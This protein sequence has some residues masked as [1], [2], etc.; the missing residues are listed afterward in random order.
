MSIFTTTCRPSKKSLSTVS[1]CAN[2]DGAV[3]T[4]TSAPSVTIASFM[5]ILRNAEDSTASADG[6]WRGN[7]LV[8]C[9][10]LEHGGRH[11]LFR[12]LRHNGANVDTAH[13][14]RLPHDDSALGQFVQPHRRQHP[15][16]LRL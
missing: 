7:F 8:G 9:G 1:D 12:D 15:G 4:T 10:N 16:G 6:R 11:L 2:A 14:D 13:L 5:L 3:R